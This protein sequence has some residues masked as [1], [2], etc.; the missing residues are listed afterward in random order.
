MRSILPAE[1]LLDHS[2]LNKETA[3][4]F[5]VLYAAGRLPSGGCNI[6]EWKGTSSRKLPW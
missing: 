2:R 4:N 5:D 1:S 3:W 6:H